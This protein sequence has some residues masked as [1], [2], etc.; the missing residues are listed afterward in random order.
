MVFSRADWLASG[1]RIW[2]EARRSGF[3]TST[4][5]V[6]IG[7]RAPDAQTR[8]TLA[9]YL[10]A[11]DGFAL[12]DADAYEPEDDPNEVIAVT[13]PRRL[14]RSEFD[15]LLEWAAMVANDH[16]AVPSRVGIER[17]GAAA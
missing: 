7:W 15:R 4:V 12:A 5:C 2:R 17:P 8:R 3:A 14:K 13:H 1:S 6:S 16:H 9:K 10:A 11:L